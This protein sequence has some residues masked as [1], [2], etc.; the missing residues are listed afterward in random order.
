MASSLFQ[1]MAIELYLGALLAMTKVESSRDFLEFGAPNA[2][3]S[4]TNYN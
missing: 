1:K 4:L 2:P 3:Y